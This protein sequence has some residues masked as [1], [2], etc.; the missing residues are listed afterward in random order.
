[1]QLLAVFLVAVLGLTFFA[2]PTV[3]AGWAWDAD[4]ALGFAALAGLLYLSIPGIARRD[5]RAHQ[6]LSYSVLAVILVHA[7]W[8]LFADPAAVEYIKPGAPGYMWTGLGAVLLLF[9]LTMLASMPTRA[10]FHRNYGVFRHWHRMLAAAVVLLSA[11]HVVFSGYYLRNGW[12]LAGLSSLVALVLLG[13]GLWRKLPPLRR[14]TPATLL[15]MS[16]LAALAFATIRNFG[17]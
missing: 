16:F 17:A 8:F 3:G 1:M 12:Q 9:V 6:R 5:I 2:M 15:S 4:N 14:S 10:R 11:H 7:L 13:G